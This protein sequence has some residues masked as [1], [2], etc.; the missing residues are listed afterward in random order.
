MVAAGTPVVRIAH[1]GPRD[2][3][4]SVPEDQVAALRKRGHRRLTVRLWAAQRELGRR[5]CAKS[6]PA[7]D[8]ATRTFLR[9]GATRR[10]A[11]VR[12]A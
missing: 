9:Q 4:F 3:V 7:A 8:P 11:A 10:A 1:D 6:P 2:V 12:W 5:R